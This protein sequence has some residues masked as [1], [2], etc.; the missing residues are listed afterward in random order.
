MYLTNSFCTTCK[1]IKPPRSKHCKLCNECIGHFDHHCMWLNQCI[2]RRNYLPFLV[3][4]STHC[5]LCLYV[6]YLFIA[7][8]LSEVR[9]DNPDKDNEHLLSMHSLRFLLE[10]MWVK[11]LD[12][13]VAHK[14]LSF[15]L[16]NVVCLAVWLP[17]FLLYHVHNL[18]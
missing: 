12:F 4:V 8:L 7:M 10:C 2:S 15:I 18:F 17:F 1:L 9:R 5:F 16:V 14:F 6:V 3:L 11:L 13:S